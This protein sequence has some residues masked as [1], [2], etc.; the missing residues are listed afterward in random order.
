[1]VDG[2][3]DVEEED[4]GLGVPGQPLG[5]EVDEAPAIDEDEEFDL[6]FVDFG[7]LDLVLEFA[8]GGDGVD[9]VEDVFGFEE[10]LDRRRGYGEHFEGAECVDI[11]S[12]ED[13]GGHFADVDF[14][15]E[16]LVEEVDVVEGYLHG[17]GGF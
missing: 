8:I 7:L 14:F 15:D 9:F 5:C 11:E 3:V 13:D 6:F 4:F 17:F 2:L 16:L 1:M 12:G 10:F